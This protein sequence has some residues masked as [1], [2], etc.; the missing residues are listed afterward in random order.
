MSDETAPGSP[1]DAAPPPPPVEPPSGDT[2]ASA[3]PAVPAGVT[4]AWNDMDPTSRLIIGASVVMLVALVIGGLAAAWFSTGA[5]ALVIIGAAIAATATAAYTSVTNASPKPSKL[6]L[7]TIEFAAGS[8]ATVLAV[9]RVIEM[10]FDIDDLEDYGGLLG[11]LATLVL[12]GAAIAILLGAF[13]RDPTLRTP[14]HYGDASVRLAVSG[15]ALVLIG[16]GLN[17]SIGYWNMNAAATSLALL[18]IAAVVIIVAPR[19]SD[20]L[21]EVPLAWAGAIIAAV[22]LLVAV[23]LWGELMELGAEHVAL[24]VIDL[25]AFL[26]AVIGILVLIVAGALGG[27]PWLEARQARAAATARATLAAA[28]PPTTPPGAT[29]PEAPGTEAPTGSEPPTE[30]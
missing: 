22:A 8:V 14:R 6:P 10:I 16:W 18:T 1:A 4:N 3:R 20:A 21:P 25:V 7:A 29:A 19:W 28:I 11:A 5:F 27:R 15:L 17:L 12:A 24:G 26:L 13:R 9:M 2:P 30:P 23:G